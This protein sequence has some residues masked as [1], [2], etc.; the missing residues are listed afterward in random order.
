MPSAWIYLGVLAWKLVKHLVDFV[1]SCC[2]YN[3]EEL[4]HLHYLCVSFIVNN[5]VSS[6]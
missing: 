1:L 5:L 6:R 3:S 4:I 2:I